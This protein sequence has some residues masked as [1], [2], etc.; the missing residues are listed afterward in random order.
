ML[1]KGPI[2]LSEKPDRDWQQEMSD[3]AFIMIISN[4]YIIFNKQIKHRLK[5]IK[6]LNCFC[7]F[8]GTIGIVLVVTIFYCNRFPPFW[9]IKK[10]A[11]TMKILYYVTQSDSVAE[12]I[13]NVIETFGW[14]Y[15][16]DI[17]RT[18]ES[19]KHRLCQPS[20]NLDIVVLTASNEE[21]LLQIYSLG[22]FLLDLR[23]V[24]ILPDRKPNTISKA[25]ALGPQFL[26]YM[27]SSLEEVK[28]VLNRMLEN[29]IS[30][31]A[32]YA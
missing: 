5:G 7:I 28:R 30:K 3:N 12:Q 10:E 6:K 26:T 18:F 8:L 19:L 13:Q 20:N 11:P 25:H 23:I 21:E 24:L 27:D 9:Q 14:K 17:C 2:N 22:A 32:C 16:S 29:P 15:H 31:K 1:F 4:S